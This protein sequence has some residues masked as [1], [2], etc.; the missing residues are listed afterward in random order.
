MRPG[1]YVQVQP[2]LEWG[3]PMRRPATVHALDRPRGELTLQLP[4]G[5]PATGW[6]RSLRPGDRTDLQGP[7]GKPL[8]LEPRAHHVLLVGEGAATGSLRPIAEDAIASGRRVALLAG[9]TDA[10][11]V[12][13]SSLLPD[14]VEYVVATADGSLGHHGTADELVPDY[15]AW[16][17][18]AIASGPTDLLVALVR[19]AAGR[20]ARLGVA[21]LGARHGR[22]R[23][24]T[25]PRTP[26]EWLHVLLTPVV[27]CA[28][29]VC[30]GCVVDAADGPV[31][32]CR[33]GPAFRASELDW[34][35]P[36]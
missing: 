5:G 3:A 35:E 10:T 34:G 17:D 29:G 15:E 31:R 6:L 13:P 18:Q 8:R 33:E 9:A 11:S 30:L 7:I 28:L 36:A 16:A 1:Q 14:E 25:Q 2:P 19:L 12:Y 32:L 21:R 23:R 4:P 20:D 27:G 24:T 22:T 26:R